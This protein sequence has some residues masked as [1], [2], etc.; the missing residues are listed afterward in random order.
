MKRTLTVCVTAQNDVIVPLKSNDKVYIEMSTSFDI[1]SKLRDFGL[2]NIVEDILLLLRISDLLSS[3]LVCKSWHTYIEEGSHWRRRLKHILCDN[4]DLMKF[5][6]SEVGEEYQYDPQLS[7]SK[8]HTL[9]R[10]WRTAE[11]KE[12]KI[13]VKSFVLSILCSEDQKS[14]VIGLNDGEIQIRELSYSSGFKIIKNISCH[15]K[16]VKTLARWMKR[17]VVT[18]S[19]DGNIKIWNEKDWT[20]VKA[21]RL[22]SDSVWDCR[23][24][25]PYLAACSL[26]GTIFLFQYDEKYVEDSCFHLLRT[27]VDPGRQISSLDLNYSTLLEG[28]DDGV[29]LVRTIDGKELRALRGHTQG[30][31][32]IRFLPQS[33]GSL[34]VSGSYD[35]YLRIWNVNHGY[36]L[37]VLVGHRDFIR[38]LAVNESRLVSGDF[39]GFVRVWDMSYIFKEINEYLSGILMKIRSGSNVEGRAPV[40]ILAHRSFYPHRGHVTSLI[41][42]PTLLITGSR[43]RSVA[44]LDFWNIKK[45]KTY[46]S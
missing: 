17:Y 24:C 44:C 5:L 21:I 11:P 25:D 30:V 1:L 16:G 3:Q 31:T 18:G 38:S 42:E 19:Y 45:E 46:Y 28:R 34:A 7:F 23:T 37:A 15:T 6:K 9:N 26:D 10:S 36:C 33:E 4:A 27:I 40:E 32:G 43:E 35:S 8:I 22:N 41:L 12:I 20:L 39:G 13:F 29:I 14:L 2:C